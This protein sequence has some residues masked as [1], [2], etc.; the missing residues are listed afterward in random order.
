MIDKDHFS[1]R[2]LRN[3]TNWSDFDMVPCREPKFIIRGVYLNRSERSV[4]L[5]LRIRLL[6]KYWYLSWKIDKSLAK[7]YVA[8]RW[9]LFDRRCNIYVNGTLIFFLKLN[10]A[11][12]QWRVSTHMAVTSSFDDA[13]RLT[14]NH[15]LRNIPRLSFLLSFEHV[16]WLLNLFYL[17]ILMVL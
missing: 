3:F 13:L 6:K 17:T 15:D 14:S 1:S 12:E 8:A 2:K 5:V 9:C 7:L 10:L 11:F 16:L 4:F